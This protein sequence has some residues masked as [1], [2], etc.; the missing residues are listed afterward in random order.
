MDDITEVLYAVQVENNSVFMLI[1]M[2]YF[3]IACFIYYENNP[4]LL[5]WNLS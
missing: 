4:L 1:L 5:Q 2:V 3:E